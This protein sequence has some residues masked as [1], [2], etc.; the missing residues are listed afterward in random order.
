MFPPSDSFL[1]Q[2]QKL[3]EARA[4]LQTQLASAAPPPYSPIPPAMP[5]VEESFCDDTEGTEDEGSHEICPITVNID[6]S[7]QVLG[8]GNTIA[9][10]SVPSYHQPGLG[11]QSTDQACRKSSTWPSSSQLLQPAQKH[12]QARLTDLAASIVAAIQQ[13]NLKA[14]GENGRLGPVEININTGLK[15]E[16]SRNTICA[17]VTLSGRAL[18]NKKIETNQ[19]SLC[20]DQEERGRKRRAQSEPAETASFKIARAN[21]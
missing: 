5:S 8:H 13:S 10:P 6:A 14:H 1:H 18:G 19:Q 4:E 15:I 20:T 11:V 9:M 17:G 16:G 2:F 3:A 21:Y 12:R 7:I